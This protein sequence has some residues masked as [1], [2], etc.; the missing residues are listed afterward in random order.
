[1]KI[2][3]IIISNKMSKMYFAFSIPIHHIA[4]AWR[5][6]ILYLVLIQWVCINKRASRAGQR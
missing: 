5:V 2:S 1:M 6:I 3:L 4:V